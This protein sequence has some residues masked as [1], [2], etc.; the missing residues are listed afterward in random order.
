LFSILVFH[1]E[2]WE[3]ASEDSFAVSRGDLS[4][5]AFIINPERLQTG[6][7]SGCLRGIVCV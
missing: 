1:K 4:D 6:E 2:S 5:G 3:D 7:G